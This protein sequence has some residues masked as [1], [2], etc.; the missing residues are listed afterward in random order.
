[1]PGMALVAGGMTLVKTHTAPVPGELGELGDT[2]T[3]KPEVEIWGVMTK[4][5]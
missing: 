4:K 1:M 3:M 2:Q 5:V